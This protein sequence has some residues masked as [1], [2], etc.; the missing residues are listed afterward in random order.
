MPRDGN[1]LLCNLVSHDL[2][3]AITTPLFGSYATDQL[4]VLAAHLFVEASHRLGGVLSLLLGASQFMPRL[5]ARNP[6]LP[7]WASR[8]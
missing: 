6:G 8:W 7:R 3:V 4:P 5:R 1:G 2:H